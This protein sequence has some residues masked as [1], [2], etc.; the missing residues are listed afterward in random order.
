MHFLNMPE[1]KQLKLKMVKMETHYTQVQFL[2]T[3]QWKGFLLYK[4]LCISKAQ[5]PQIIIRTMGLTSN[6]K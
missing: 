1:G 5:Q 2:I 3:A 4:R 6:W